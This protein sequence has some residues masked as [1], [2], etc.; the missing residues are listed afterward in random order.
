M[1]RHPQFRLDRDDVE[2]EEGHDEG[3]AHETFGDEDAEDDVHADVDA[4]HKPLL[5]Y[6]TT[7]PSWFDPSLYTF[8]RGNKKLPLLIPPQHIREAFSRGGGKGGQAINKNMSRCDLTHTPT[9]LLVR[10]QKTRSLEQNRVIAQRRLA[11]LVDWHL[12]GEE[13]A[14]GQEAAVR[15]RKKERAAK[16]ARRRARDRRDEHKEGDGEASSMPPPPQLGAKQKR[17]MR[18]QAKEEKARQREESRR[19]KQQ[20]KR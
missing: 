7:P 17:A 12:R 16:A 8:Q 3:D 14:M 4:T 9:S 11:R 15:R 18:Q 20:Q 6:G 10:C 2:D 5:A 13:S 19:G 1:Y